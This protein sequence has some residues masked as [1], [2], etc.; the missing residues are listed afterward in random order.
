MKWSFEVVQ[1]TI[2]FTGFHMVFKPI[3][4]SSSSSASDLQ[5][6]DMTSFFLHTCLSA[7]AVRSSLE[8]SLVSFWST[9]FGVILGRPVLRHSFDVQNN[10]VFAGS[11]CLATCP[12]SAN[13]L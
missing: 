10:R 11:L 7:I 1:L 3:C 9:F 2:K 12:A 13:R 4:S 6:D 5:F 8:V